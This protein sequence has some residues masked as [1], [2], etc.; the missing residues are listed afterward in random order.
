[1][2]TLSPADE[3]GTGTTSDLSRDL[4]DLAGFLGFLDFF[5]SSLGTTMGVSGSQT[6]VVKE[7]SAASQ[8]GYRGRLKSP[9]RDQYHAGKTRHGK[10]PMTRSMPLG[11]CFVT[12]NKH[13]LI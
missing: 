12:G 11:P 1:L 6:Q 7:Q 4:L 8:E 10:S 13:Q 5:G 2:T 9:Q 3:A